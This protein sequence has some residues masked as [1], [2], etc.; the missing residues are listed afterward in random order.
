VS[1]R[2]PRPP[3]KVRGG[4]PDGLQLNGLGDVAKHFL[5]AEPDPK[6]ALVQLGRRQLIHDDE[7]GSDIAVLEILAI[8]VPGEAGQLELERQILAHRDQRTA[9]GT[10]P[11]DQPYE[12]ND[13][14][15]ALDLAHRIQVWA[16]LDSKDPRAEW[17]GFFGPYGDGVPTG[18]RGGT[19]EH[20]LQFCE[21]F[22]IPT[23]DEPASVTGE[24]GFN[25]EPDD[26]VESGWDD[27]PPGRA[28]LDADL[29]DDP[30][31]A[32]AAFSH[33]N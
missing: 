25:D 31:P 20:L 10:L 8:E 32:A 27:V 12:S 9:V 13:A 21:H 24:P 26:D 33:T 18:P 3:V 14:D 4:V 2:I 23:R 15:R 1:D 29:P 22:G 30:E 11:F 17:E 6:F 5:R 16:D 19:L 28:V 7:E